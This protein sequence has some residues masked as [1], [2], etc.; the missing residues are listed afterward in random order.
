MVSFPE[1]FPPDHIA[2]LKSDHFYSGFPK[3]LQAMVA[4]LKANTHEKMYSNYLQAAR[5]AEKEEVME[6]SCSQMADNQPKPKAT[7]FFPLQKL[8]DTQL[9][10]TPAV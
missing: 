8:K 4:Y 5:G 9:V 6:P 3:Q 1:H 2:E 10:K 7:S